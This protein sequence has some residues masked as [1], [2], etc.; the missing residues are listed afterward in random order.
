MADVQAF[1]Q[2]DKS[3]IMTC[4]PFHF[5]KSGFTFQL[6]YCNNNFWEYYRPVIGLDAGIQTGRG[7]CIEK[8]CT[9]GPCGPPNIPSMSSQ[10]T[11]R[12]TPSVSTVYWQSQSFDVVGICEEADMHTYKPNALAIEQRSILASAFHLSALLTFL[13]CV[14]INYLPPHSFSIV[15]PFR[16]PLNQRENEKN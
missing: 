9:G 4:K 10:K 5:T 14:S 3:N 12:N 6:D 2:S 11:N 13:G 1:I 16:P 7:D 15:S 8:R